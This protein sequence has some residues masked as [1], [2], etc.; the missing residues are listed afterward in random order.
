[1]STRW[2]IELEWPKTDTRKEDDPRGSNRSTDQL[3]EDRGCNPA[4]HTATQTPPQSPPPPNTTALPLHPTTRTARSADP[5]LFSLW[6]T[7]TTPLSPQPPGSSRPPARRSSRR[8]P[9]GAH[10]P[11]FW[12]CRATTRWLGSIRARRLWRLSL[13]SPP[14]HRRCSPL[15]WP[16]F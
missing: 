2:K 16:W 11:S 8:G 14:L 9:E 13:L 12:E 7:G 15:P 4:P 6:C 5:T 10:T 1:M 3:G